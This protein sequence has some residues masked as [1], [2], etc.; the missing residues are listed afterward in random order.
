MAGH[1]A[2][3]EEAEGDG[4]QHPADILPAPSAPT[5]AHGVVLQPL[6]RSF[7]LCQTFL[8]ACS[9]TLLELQRLGDSKSGHIDSGLWT[10][11][12][13]LTMDNYGRNDIPQ[14][15]RCTSHPTWPL[16]VAQRC[17]SEEEICKT[18]EN[19]LHFTLINFVMT[20]REAVQSSECETSAI[21]IC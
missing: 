17:C 6:Q 20:R 1:V 3:S 7:L 15:S 2:P 14:H 10:R 9:Q 5:P 12:E 11:S 16:A 19:C 8:E 18:A 21:A 4:Y 13:N